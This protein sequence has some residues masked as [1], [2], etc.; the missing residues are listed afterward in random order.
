MSVPFCFEKCPEN[1]TKQPG[2]DTRAHK[3]IGTLSRPDFR[4]VCPD[5]VSM[6][7]PTK[8]AQTQAS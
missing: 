7:V 8:Y 1:G 4:P 3:E 5:F 2:R 6:S